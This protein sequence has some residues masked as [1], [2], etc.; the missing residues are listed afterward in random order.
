[1]RTCKANFSDQERS[2]FLRFTRCLLT[3]IG[4][5]KPMHA[6]VRG[7]QEVGDTYKK[8]NVKEW[9]LNSPF[10]PFFLPFPM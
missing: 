8:K 6:G 2:K 5:E 10:V 4:W 1:M 3:E 7:K 9:R